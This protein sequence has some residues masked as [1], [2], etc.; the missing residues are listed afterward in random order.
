MGLKQFHRG[1]RHRLKYIQLRLRLRV[2]HLSM[3]R[4]ARSALALPYEA[5]LPRITPARSQAEQQT[6]TAP[7]SPPLPAVPLPTLR[8]P[9]NRKPGQ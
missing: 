9:V 8:R 6:L 7:A 1:M 2:R 5:P 3:H 4:K